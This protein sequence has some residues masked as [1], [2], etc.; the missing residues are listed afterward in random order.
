M[1]DYDELKRKFD[2]LLEENKALKARILE[3]E[4]KSEIIV[5][6]HKIVQSRETLFQEPKEPVKSL[7]FALIRLS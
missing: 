7:S 4:S 3:L 2:I 5:S 6:D 1:R